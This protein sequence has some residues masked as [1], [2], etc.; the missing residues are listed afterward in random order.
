MLEI[1]ANNKHY[2]IKINEDNL[3]AED[4]SYIEDYINKINFD[5]IK[6]PITVQLK[7]ILGNKFINFACERNHY[8]MTV[9]VFEMYYEKESVMKCLA[10]YYSDVVVQFINNVYAHNETMEVLDI[11]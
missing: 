1:Y 2:T 9:S 6:V 4:M 10:I 7:A 11:T 8:I 3:I 5:D